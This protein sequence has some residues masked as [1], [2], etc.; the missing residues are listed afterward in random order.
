MCKAS[1]TTGQWAICD[2]KRGAANILNN[3]GEFLFAESSEATNSASANWDFLSN[4][5]KAR[6][7]YAA[8]NTSGVTYIYAAFAANP[9]VLTDGTPVTAV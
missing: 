6:A 1:S 5:L 8:N 9:F 4:G 3:N 7:G 2:N